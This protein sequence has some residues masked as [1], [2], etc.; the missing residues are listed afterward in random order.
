MSVV[1]YI[2]SLFSISPWSISTLLDDS[3]FR[4]LVTVKPVFRLRGPVLLGWLCVCCVCDYFYLLNKGD[5]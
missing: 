5:S 3:V 2:R 4:P 1:P